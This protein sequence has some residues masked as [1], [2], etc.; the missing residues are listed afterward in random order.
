MSENPAR[1]ELHL[2]AVPPLQ[3]EAGPDP[4]T[5]TAEMTAGEWGEIPAP[6]VQP[7]P[8]QPGRLKRAAKWVMGKLIDRTPVE[9]EST[10]FVDENGDTY[11][12][13]PDFLNQGRVF[14]YQ[15]PL[16]NVVAVEHV[17]PRHEK[18]HDRYLVHDTKDIIGVFD[19]VGSSD[20]P[21][22]AAEAAIEAAEEFFEQE[23]KPSQLF[24]AQNQNRVLL[25]QMRDQ[26]AK[27]KSSTT[28]EVLR[29]LTLNGERVVVGA[30]AGDSRSG[31]LRADGTVHML[32]SDQS[33]DADKRGLFNVITNGV[34]ARVPRHYQGGAKDETNAV[35]LRDG[36]RIF[37]ATDGLF[38]DDRRK[39]PDGTTEYISDEEFAQFYAENSHL[40]SKELAL[41]FAKLSRKR[42]RDDMTIL[43]SDVK[44]MPYRPSRVEQLDTRRR[45]RVQHRLAAA[46]LTLAAVLAP[47]TF[48]DGVVGQDKNTEASADQPI[49]KKAPAKV[50]MKAEKAINTTSTSGNGNKITVTK[51]STGTIQNISVEM[52]AAS[53][54]SFMAYDANVAAGNTD[55]TPEE[56]AEDNAFMHGDLI[57]KASSLQWAKMSYGVE[58]GEPKLIKTDYR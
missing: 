19:G 49:A 29:L 13:G 18:G 14:E 55:A 41:A 6:E 15:T 47:A 56:I 9:E 36:D 1:P 11:E 10:L 8:K 33:T 43:I 50:S 35:P 39:R 48:S 25:E 38:G 54:P 53:N 51:D 12:K 30:S 23:P 7:V 17:S 46:A 58:K 5:E 2:S 21:H 42:D 27:T 3:L 16:M 45:K 40:P 20:Q 24:I 26:V 44:P 37:S 32:S 4:V 52:G 31:V 22:L 57:N 28:V 34:S